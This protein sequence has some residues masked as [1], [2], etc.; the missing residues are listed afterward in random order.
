MITLRFLFMINSLVAFSYGFGALIAP[1]WVMSAYG[2]VLT[3]P[4]E[5]MT[6]FYAAEL[7]AH[8]WMTWSLAEYVLKLST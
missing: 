7:I 8:G 2:L 5:L 3:P 4:G 6:R 1:A